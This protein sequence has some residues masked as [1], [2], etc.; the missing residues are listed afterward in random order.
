MNEMTAEDF[1]NIRRRDSCRTLPW[2]AGA[3]AIG[4][5]LPAQSDEPALAKTPPGVVPASVPHPTGKIVLKKSVRAKT[6]IPRS[7]RRPPARS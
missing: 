2:P 3:L 5:A 4:R 1:R 7:N 6:G